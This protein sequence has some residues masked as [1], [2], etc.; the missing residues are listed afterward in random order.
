MAL[1]KFVVELRMDVDQH[2]QEAR[3]QLLKQLKMQ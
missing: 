1:K 3:I 2:G